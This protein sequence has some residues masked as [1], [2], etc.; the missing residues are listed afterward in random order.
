M[1]DNSS[2][3]AIFNWSGGKDSSLALHQILNAPDEW[4]V[5]GLL[6]TF[7]ES[8][9]RLSMHG[10]RRLLM[11]AQAKSIGLPL[12]EINFPETLDMAS[13]DSIMDRELE[14]LKNQYDF[15]HSIFG[16]IFLEDLRAYREEKLGQKQ[17]KGVFPLWNKDTE[18]LAN[19]FVEEGFKAKVVCV[20][21]P[22]LGESH[23]GANF[24]KSFIS[25]LPEAVD[26]CGENGEFHTFVYDGPIFDT[27][28]PIQTGEK[29]FK[30]LDKSIRSDHMDEESKTNAPDGFWYCDL[31]PTD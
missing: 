14:G 6:S 29:V 15:T 22:I 13:Y 17:L 19:Q 8:V 31:H 7:N 10:V 28:I 25:M 12:F 27:S 3:R 5:I 2:K 20:S 24:D 16:D 11:Q 30:P 4:E 21:S 23:V 1:V 18:A 9:D 26:P